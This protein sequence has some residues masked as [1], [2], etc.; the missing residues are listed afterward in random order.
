[1]KFYNDFTSMYN[2]Q[3]SPTIVF[4]NVDFSKNR[5]GTTT[6]ATIYSREG[7]EIGRAV[8]VK[9]PQPSV[10]YGVVPQSVFG[11]ELHLNDRYQGLEDDL[12]FYIS[13]QNG[14]SIGYADWHISSYNGVLLFVDSF[15]SNKDSDYGFRKTVKT[16]D[17]FFDDYKVERENH[18][19]LAR[20]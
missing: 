17:K 5:I 20:G 18:G 13:K 8:V 14:Q 2:A 6:G 12:A 4:N 7:D 16:I 1:M 3:Y 9:L 10:L 15:D 11:F 19:L